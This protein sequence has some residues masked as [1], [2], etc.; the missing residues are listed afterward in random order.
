LPKVRFSHQ[1]LEITATEFGQILTQNITITNPIPD[2]VLSGRFS[3]APHP[4][5][6]PHTPYDHAWIS[7]DPQQ[8]SGNEV[9]CQITIDTS[10][11]LA[12]ET[13][14]REVLL[15][16]NSASDIDRLTVNLQTA[17]LPKK[18]KNLEF[19]L[20]LLLL[21]IIMACNGYF[22]GQH[23]LL[24]IGLPLL[25][26]LVSLLDFK[27]TILKSDQKID[28][29][30]FIID[31]FID[32]NNRWIMVLFLFFSPLY[33]QLFGFFL[34]SLSWVM[35]SNDI[36]TQMGIGVCIIMVLLL[37]LFGVWL[38]PL[39]DTELFEYLKIILKLILPIFIVFIVLTIRLIV[40]GLNNLGFNEKILAFL[41][42]LGIGIIPGTRVTFKKIIIN[43]KSMLFDPVVNLL[44][45]QSTDQSVSWLTCTLGLCLG[46]SYLT[47]VTTIEYL[48][49]FSI[50]K[51]FWIAGLGLIPVLITSIPLISYLIQRIQQAKNV[52]KYR[53][54]EST[55]IKP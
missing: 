30:E 44:N 24:F 8:F 25:I 11:L 40:F 39:C 43:L 37:G 33:T 7:F 55:L 49:N 16:S 23:L 21:L 6:P 47:Y 53:R 51:I 12:G 13:Y 52:A 50:E 36:Q 27:Q 41:I 26:I 10:Q 46:A 22:L 15:D 42:I 38:F 54:S 48:A 31:L 9:K 20:K 3:V 19:W 4:S 34:K 28:N 18:K 29:Q 5:D 45:P 1:N 14:T 35:Y 17:P 32:Y 2:T